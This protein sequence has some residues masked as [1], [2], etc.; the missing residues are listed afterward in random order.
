MEW[1]TEHDLDAI[2]IRS[3]ANLR[4]LTGF[5]GEGLAVIGVAGRAVSTD[6]RYAIEVKEE[7]LGYKAVLVPEGHLAGALQFLG[8]IECR[9]LAFEADN[10]CYSE[11]ETLRKKLKGVKLKGVKGVVEGQRRV[12]DAVEIALIRQAAGIVDRVL[13]PM[14]AAPP[15]GITEKE[16]A[17]R[18][19]TEMLRAGADSIAFDT[20]AAVGPHAAQCHAVPGNDILRR[21]QMLKVDCGACVGGYRSDITR[22]VFMGKPTKQF[23]DVYTAVYDA[24]QAAVKAVRAG[25]GGAELDRVARGVLE[26]RGYG[27]KFGHGL[28]HGVGLQIHEGPGLG[29]RSQDT[30]E[31]GMVV[32]VEPGVYIEGWGGVRVEDT[33]VVTT[34]GCEVL[35]NTPKLQFD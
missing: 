24:Q 3:P 13:T 29:T 20:I 15:L 25:V 12:K 17:L 27:D 7:A 1:L 14:L 28:G 31:K 35:T 23:R 5:T 21:G 16:F 34:R 9:A 4:Y 10:T 32:T 33:V 26:E 2:L 6:S 8:E 19:E 30:L 18:L 11:F 22:T